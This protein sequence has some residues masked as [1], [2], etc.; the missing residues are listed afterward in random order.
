[1]PRKLRLEYPGAIYHVINRGNYRGWIFKE[2]GAKRAFEKCLFEACEKS[3]RDAAPAL[4][5]D[6]RFKKEESRSVGVTRGF[7]EDGAVV[8]DGRRCAGLAPT[9]GD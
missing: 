1:M 2:E 5:A 9:R 8:F 3:G 7:K 6:S 4:G